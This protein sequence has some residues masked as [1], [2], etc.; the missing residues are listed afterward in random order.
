[1]IASYRLCDAESLFFVNGTCG[2]LFANGLHAY[3]IT[4]YA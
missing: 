1:M 3:L 2:G 4:M